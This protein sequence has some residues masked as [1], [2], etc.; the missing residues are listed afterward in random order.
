[1]QDALDDKESSRQFYAQV[2]SFEQSAVSN[3]PQDR[4]G[5]RGFSSPGGVLRRQL[6]YLR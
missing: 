6:S 3:R 2:L 1:M 5:V 4:S